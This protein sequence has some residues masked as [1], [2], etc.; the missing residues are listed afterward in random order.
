[1]ATP[2]YVEAKHDVTNETIEPE[3]ILNEDG[4]KS[5][6]YVVV[7]SDDEKEAME[8]F[9]YSAGFEIY[10]H[11]KTIS[12]GCLAALCEGYV[13]KQFREGK[14]LDCV[15]KKTIARRAIEERKATSS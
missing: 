7:L 9:G 12:K 8:I 14:P 2:A 13:T 1:M 15:C 3:E 11:T 4:S 6:R 10:Q 5:Y